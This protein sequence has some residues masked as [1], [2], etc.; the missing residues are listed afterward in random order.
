MKFLANVQLTVCLVLLLVF[1][2]EVTTYRTLFGAVESEPEQIQRNV[3]TFLD[4]LR[5]ETLR[6]RYHKSPKIKVQQGKSFLDVSRISIDKLRQ[7][8]SFDRPHK[9]LRECPSTSYHNKAF[10]R[11]NHYLGN[12]E[13]YTYRVNDP[14]Q[15]AKKNRRMWDEQAQQK[16]TK[17]GDEA[18]PW[19]AG[20]VK[21][22]G[23]EQ[24]KFL[25]NGCG[26]DPNYTA[27]IQDSWL[28]ARDKPI[29]GK[30]KKTKRR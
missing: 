6:W 19:I 30:K 22:F 8:D 12:W 14:R 23:M 5:F 29:S 9:L 1:F 25:L 10:L 2:T 21:Y 18:R 13:Y 27:P 16:D 24:S 3:P 17:N 20:F 26:L 4:P 7:K 15:G 11:I 28:L